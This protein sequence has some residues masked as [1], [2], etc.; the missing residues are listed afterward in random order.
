MLFG[1]T[2][3]I[4]RLPDE[5]QLVG[6]E[7]WRLY[8]RE[9]L[10]AVQSRGLT[11]YIDGMIPRPNSYPGLIYPSAQTT[12]PLFSST[13]CLEEWEACDRLIAGAIVS[14]ITNPVGLGID[15]TK[16]AS[17]TW[18]A[19]IKRF[20]KC[21]E[22]CI[23]LAD[24]NIQQEKFNPV[25]LTMEDHE[26]QMRNLIKKVHNLGGTATDAQ[27]HRI[28]ISSM[29]SDWRQDIRSIPGASSADVFAY[30]H[31]LWYKKEEEWKEEE[32][33]T[34]RVKA[35]MAVNST[36]NPTQTN[37][38]MVLTCHNC[39][40][41]RHIARKCWAKGGGMEGQWPKQNQPNKQKNGTN[42]NTVSP[43]GTEITYP[44][45]TYVMSIHPEVNTKQIHPGI[46]ADR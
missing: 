4:P 17:E 26:K 38:R 32:R 27:F 15:E 37:S 24:M 29:P 21:N 14:N 42:M 34:K 2:P 1:N 33:D 46:P 8:K 22:Q 39:N 16:R 5:K 7:N 30:L 25:K 45:A 10:F 41:P 43:D 3:N 40:R 6:K 28:V 18:T 19:L 13:P 9:I 35:L 20:E 11:G 44:M 36:N 23:Y 12:T 31:M